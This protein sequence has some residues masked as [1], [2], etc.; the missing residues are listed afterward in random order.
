MR[1]VFDAKMVKTAFSR[2]FGYYNGGTWMKGML[3]QTNG[4]GFEYYQGSGYSSGTYG[5]NTNTRISYDIQ[6][7]GASSY[8]KINGGTWRSFTCQALDSIEVT[9][10]SLNGRVLQDASDQALT[11]YNMKIYKDDILERDFIPVKTNK[12]LDK[13]KNATN[14]SENIPANTYCFYDNVTGLYYLNS[15]GGSFTDTPIPD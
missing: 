4:S 13:S 10:F 14:S 15:G 1:F 12:E 3:V 6:F 7:N 11:M 5:G 8:I 9:L 2:P